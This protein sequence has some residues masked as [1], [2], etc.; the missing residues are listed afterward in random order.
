MRAASVCA[1]IL[2]GLGIG[3]L[4]PYLPAC[5][6]SYTPPAGYPSAE[7][8]AQYALTEQT[9]VAASSTRMSAEECINATRVAFCA[10]YP[11]LAMCHP[12]GGVEDGGHRD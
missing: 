9:C 2:L 11:A 5:S 6:G 3:Y 1:R 12:D 8:V 7:A 10:S 4:L